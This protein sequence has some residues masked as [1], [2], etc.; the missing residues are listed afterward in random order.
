MEIDGREKPAVYIEDFASDNYLEK[1]DS[2]DVGGKLLLKFIKAY[3]QNYLDRGKMMPLYM[4]ARS[5]TS[6]AL[7][8]KHMQSLGKKWG[9]RF[10]MKEVDRRETGSTTMH[11]VVLTP[12]KIE[13]AAL[14]GAR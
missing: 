6:H 5:E 4:N 14:V 10:E 3:K 11:D 8:M 9:Y 1:V 13:A 2:S 7:L 12:K